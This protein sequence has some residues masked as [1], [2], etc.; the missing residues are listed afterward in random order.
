M[1]IDE[2]KTQEWLA[3]AREINR[4]W[5]EGLLHQLN[6]DECLALKVK[7]LMSDRHIWEEYEWMKEYGNS[8]FQQFNQLK[9][10]KQKYLPGFVEFKVLGKNGA[11]LDTNQIP[12]G[13]NAKEACK[14]INLNEEHY[15]YTAMQLP[16]ASYCWM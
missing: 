10:T 5:R 7:L 3:E 2:L 6:V 13:N 9:N 16:K 4:I 12:E 14:P 8:I 11:I 15:D 1:L